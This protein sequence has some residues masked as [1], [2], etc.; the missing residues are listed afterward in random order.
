MQQLQSFWL[1]CDREQTNSRDIASRTVERRYGSSL[2]RIVP[3]NDHDWNCRSRG[4]G[5]RRRGAS[6]DRND[7]GDTPFHQL[8]G[9]L[10]QPIILS[11][12]P[13]IFDREV[14]S[15]DIA[16]LAQPFFDRRDRGR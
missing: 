11:L 9:E 6:S 10:R 15:L 8:A 3:H 16:C 14:A 12:R 4:L 5:S 13:T 1:H 2:D 7:D